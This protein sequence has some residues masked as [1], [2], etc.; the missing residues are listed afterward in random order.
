MILYTNPDRRYTGEAYDE[1]YSQHPDRF[2]HSITYRALDA[3]F[4]SRLPLDRPIRVLDL[5]CGQGQVISYVHRK[6]QECAPQHERGSMLYGLDISE[7]AIAQCEQ[8]DSSVHWIVDTF[9]DFLR[10]E[11]SQSLK[12]VFDLVINKGGLT[13]VESAEDYRAMLEGVGDLLRDGGLYLFLQYK[14][15]YQ[16][17][18]N[19]HCL[20]WTT[21]IFELGEQVLGEPH[22]IE[23]GSAY[24]CVHRKGA[25]KPTTD[26]A[27]P[28]RIRFRMSDGSE[29]RVFI[30]GDELTAQRLHRLRAAPDRESFL[31]FDLPADAKDKDIQRHE[32]RVQAARERFVPGRQRVLLGTGRVR[33]TDDARAIDPESALFDALSG[34]YNILA[35][36]GMVSTVRHLCKVV[37]PWSAARPDLVVIG[38]GLEDFKVD[39][40]TNQPIVDADEFR[41][42]LDWVVDVLT[43][44]AGARVVYLATPPVADFTDER[45]GSIY[46]PDA[47]QPF[48]DA[49]GE[50]CRRYRAIFDDVRRTGRPARRGDVLSAVAARCSELL[51]AKETACAR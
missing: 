49:A 46:R 3:L 28:Q 27:K 51:R 26:R 34:S 8:R 2:G 35:W 47:A 33:M 5:G 40:A 42:R 32:Q 45:N 30:S 36:P 6:L 9:Q 17:W 24:I 48:L 1:T 10:R 4:A 21:D 25:P 7:V 14:Q 16:V 43:G 44:E 41:H 23:D 22:R 18:S 37:A 11:E 39:P 50:V 20:D 19:A 31:A 12:G 13:Q 38:P 29:Q 15:F